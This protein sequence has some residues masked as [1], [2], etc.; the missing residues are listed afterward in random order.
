[1]N[2]EVTFCYGNLQTVAGNINKDSLM[3]IWKGPAAKQ[4]RSE[5]KHHFDLKKEFWRECRQC[6]HLPVDGILPKDGLMMGP[7]IVNAP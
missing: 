3:D 2:G 5:M 7:L 6:P 1:M 4:M